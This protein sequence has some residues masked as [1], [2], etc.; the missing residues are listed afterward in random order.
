MPNGLNLLLWDSVYLLIDD[1]D[2]NKISDLGV[3]YLR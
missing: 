2:N 1:L 3:K